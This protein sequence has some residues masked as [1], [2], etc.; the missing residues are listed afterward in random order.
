MEARLIS[1][2]QQRHTKVELRASLS[3]KTFWEKQR[4]V[5]FTL[6]LALCRECVFSAAV[7]DIC[8]PLRD[9]K[10]T[11]LHEMIHAELFLKGVRDDGD[12][13]KVFR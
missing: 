3:I 2:Q 13:G 12:H 5:H 4:S 6:L 10:D 8:R 1:C 11:L 7:C 9:L